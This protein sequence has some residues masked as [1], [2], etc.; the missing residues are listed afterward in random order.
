MA[1]QTLP[2]SVKRQAFTLVELL[3]VIGIIALLVAILLPAL[4]RA[5]RQAATVQ[6]ASNMKQIAMAVIQYDMDNNGHLIIGHIDDYESTANGKLYP[7]GFGW[8][9]EL[10]HQNYIKAPNFLTDPYSSVYRSPFRCPEGL[11]QDV[12]QSG[13]TELEGHY[14]TDP[15]NAEYYID[16]NSGGSRSDGQTPYAVATWY[17]L[18]L[19][20]SSTASADYPGGANATPFLWFNPTE[21]NIGGGNVDT[22]LGDRN[23]QRNL[24]MVKRSG[25]LVMIVEAVSYNWYNVETPPPANPPILLAELSARHG[26][27]T[28]DGY[29]AFANFAFFDGHVGLFPTYPLTRNV[30]GSAAEMQASP[31]VLLF[32][33]QQ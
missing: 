12:V 20:T 22:A 31:N 2:V 16:G 13:S 27:K 21:P 11:D 19:K 1:S 5:R 30:L 7:D 24:S 28:K 8:A 23:F 32:L 33:N 17:Q 26:Q 25:E 6:C 3:V 29:D 15:I 4:S 18:N 14:A 9:A 10:M